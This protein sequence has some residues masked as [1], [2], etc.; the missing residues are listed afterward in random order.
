MAAVGGRLAEG[1]V[2]L[3]SMVARQNL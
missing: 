3:G 2:L 1:G